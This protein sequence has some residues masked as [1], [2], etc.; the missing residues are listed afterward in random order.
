MPR[1]SAG[2]F[3]LP[4]G[5]PV[6]TGTVISSA[7]ANP[8]MADVALALTESLDRY[9]RG[10][11]LAPFKFSDGEL[12]APSLTFDSE[13]TTG[14]YR[15]G[16]YD[17]RLAIF[18]QD[19]LRFTPSG[20]EGRIIG[21]PGPV[22]PSGFQGP[23]GPQG[24]YGPIGTQGF[25]GPLGPPGPEGPGLPWI[26]GS[27]QP[28]NGVG[29]EHQ[30]YLNVDNGDVHEKVGT[31]QLAGNIRGPAGV[32]TAEGIT[33][34]GSLTGLNNPDHPIAAIQGLQGQL[35][36]LGNSILA[37][38]NQNVDV[39]YQSS[40]PSSGVSLGD[41]WFNTA[42]GNRLYRYS[43]SA[44]VD[45]ADARIS[46]SLTNA[47]S[48]VTAASNAQNTANTKITT[49]FANTTPVALSVGDLW[50]KTSD[51]NKLFRWSG[52]AWDSVAD[53]TIGQ[54]LAAAQDAQVT[55]DGK[56]VTWY[57]NSSPV[58]ASFGDLWF[59][60]DDG[61]H[62]YRYNGATWLSMRDAQ[63]SQAAAD[64]AAALQRSNEAIATAD[65]KV[66][67]FYAS[68]APTSASVGDLWINTGAGNELFRY[69]G[70]AWITA[71]DQD[72]GV[73]LT[74]SQ[75]AAATADGKIT[76]F[77]QISAPASNSGRKYGDMWIDIDDFNRP[78]RFDG[79]SWID[80]SPVAGVVGGQV[81]TSGIVLD[82]VT[83][84]ASVQ[85]ISDIVYSCSNNGSGGGMYF[86]QL[87]YNY[88]SYAED[89]NVGE[90][91][92]VSTGRPI[93]ISISGVKWGSSAVATTPGNTAYAP[94]PQVIRFGTY[95]W[96]RVNGVDTLIYPPQGS[97]SYS[98]DGASSIYVPNQVGNGYASYP[99]Y[100]QRNDI[101]SVTIMDVA[102]PVGNVTYWFSE[103][104][105]WMWG[106]VLDEADVPY[107]GP[108][109]YTMKYSVN[110]NVLLTKR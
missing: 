86:N 99:I 109:T 39:Y 37:V 60:T 10:G 82:A 88:N 84:S 14:F 9:G 34:H 98:W 4:A 55:A 61:N 47:A 43:G 105:S 3:E 106:P 6:V 95:L 108:V 79:A 97:P 44:W 42:Q 70:I 25:M 5:N 66:D 28:N 33:Y 51:N 93:L 40:A 38:S 74:N 19:V 68:T 22:G 31:W 73:A 104:A 56:I 57:Q 101:A 58:G 69:S 92:V 65:G 110:M 85:G 21:S 100:I 41:L 35:D 71:Q 26:V 8:T 11:M 32:G 77:Y 62:L 103:L 80:T 23:I 1:D 94:A 49:F 63:I 50:I 67:V 90:I 89:P 24:A 52:T 46:T 36:A 7:W 48:A 15:A 76:F 59:D 17:V 91:T 64:A 13:P 54:A 83:S 18:G 75:L 29:V 16:Q 27:G 12:A 72:V 96:R 102:P 45:V 87:G 78:Y 53:L 20:T 2:N 107:E 81:G 30:L